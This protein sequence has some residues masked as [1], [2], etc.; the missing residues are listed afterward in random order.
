MWL[1]RH[2]HGVM[3]FAA[4]T[5]FRVRVAGGAIPASGPVLLVAN[6]PNSL[7]DAALVATASGRP[8]R[9]LA[10]APL[11]EMTGI[12]WLVRGSGAIPVY[13]RSDDPAL[14]M[15]NE[16]AFSA[17]HD[18]LGAGACVGIF[19]E[20]LSH[21]EPTLAPLRSGAARIALGSLPRV[22]STF[23]ILPV[24]ITFRGAKE[25]FRSEA[26][27][28]IG[29]PVRW[30][31]LAAQAEG[32]VD[33]ESVRELTSR[34]LHGL[35]AV[36][37]NLE[38][39]ED[40]RTIEGA[41]A[42]HAAE[43]GGIHA[44][45]SHEDALRWLYRIQRTSRALTRARQ[46]GHPASE[47]LARDITRHLRT[48][49]LLGLRPADLHRAHESSV[50]LRWTLPNLLLF[51]LALPLALVGMILFFL[52]HTLVR[53]VEPR[54]SLPSDRRATYQVLGGAAAF[55]GWIL[56]IAAGLREFLGWRPALWS[57]W[58]LPLLGLL[59][60]RIRHRW[61]DALS[62]LRRLLILRGRRDLRSR[63]LQRQRDLAERIEQVGGELDSV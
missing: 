12:R 34:I 58:L 8:I 30:E 17:V 31:D 13:R 32:G 40:L 57:L 19:P 16:E 35:A 4:T 11:F 9:F 53:W 39:W 63:L 24:G 55:G 26:I 15:R 22:G 38:S 50:V 56:L 44:D 60:L 10:R 14:A 33:A 43:L 23:P 18:A 61:R 36:T 7:L 6:H 28:V 48:L 21:S 42:I 46:S 54:L 62:D 2:L 27:L 49:T 52:P 51:G 20:G 37:V 29:E 1:H 5:Y 47:P 45:P 41:E 59:T 25:A 3:T